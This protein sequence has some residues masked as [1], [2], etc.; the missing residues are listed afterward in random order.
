MG[1]RI[2]LPVGR[3]AESEKT[4][5]NAYACPWHP[6]S[7]FRRLS[8]P[9]IACQCFVPLMKGEL[10][11]SVDSMLSICARIATHA[12][13]A[14]DSPAVSDQATRLTYAG[15]EQ[16]SDRLAAFLRES[17]AGPEACVGLLLDRSTDFVVSA[18]AV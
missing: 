7:K 3:V 8:I 16:R 1:K 9:E 11:V 10:P 6:C 2:R 13:A 5:A 17:G 18:L 15:L 4:R 14:P 12:T